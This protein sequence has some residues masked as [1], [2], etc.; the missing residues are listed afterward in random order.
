[1]LADLHG[2]G[3][4]GSLLCLSRVEGL[5]VH[6]VGAV[7]AAVVFCLSRSGTL[8]AVGRVRLPKPAASSLSAIPAGLESLSSASNAFAA[9]VSSA[10]RSRRRRNVA[11]A[12]ASAVV[13]PGAKAPLPVFRRR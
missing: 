1:M 8:A 12:S 6:V 7:G 11:S 10:C 2:L 3:I 13:P 4:H 5:L 9:A